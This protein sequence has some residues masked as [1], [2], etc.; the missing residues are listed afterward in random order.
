ME[1]GFRFGVLVLE[2]NLNFS[3]RRLPVFTIFA[4]WIVMGACGEGSGFGIGRGNGLAPFGK[5]R[6]RGGGEGDTAALD[7][8][9]WCGAGGRGGGGC[10][11][12]L[13]GSM[14]LT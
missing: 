9:G 3:L 10:T 6:L 7:V 11:A 8:A 5:L 2:G 14:G 13:I 4:R 12:A 1:G